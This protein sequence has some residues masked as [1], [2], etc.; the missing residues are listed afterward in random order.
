MY[1]AELYCRIN[2]LCHDLSARTYKCDAPRLPSTAQTCMSTGPA[3]GAQIPVPVRSRKPLPATKRASPMHARC[4]PQTAP[5]HRHRRREPAR[6]LASAAGRTQAP[7]CFPHLLERIPA[8]SRRPPRARHTPPLHPSPLSGPRAGTQ[9]RRKS[10]GAIDT[11]LRSRA[12]SGGS[13]AS[14]PALV[15]GR[16]RFTCNERAAMSASQSGSSRFPGMGG[17]RAVQGSR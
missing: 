10:R 12:R 16:D 6:P 8:A 13:A 17:G 5:S 4:R 9:S 1:L 2:I 3:L 7:G 14:S 15:H 11:T